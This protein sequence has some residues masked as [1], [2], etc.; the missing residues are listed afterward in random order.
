MTTTSQLD[1]ALLRLEERE[2]S[3]RVRT[4]LYTLIP[5]VLAGALIV[6]Y[7]SWTHAQNVRLANEIQARKDDA[8]DAEL[9]AANER[10]QFESARRQD[11]ERQVQG[12]IDGPV[13]AYAR[14][15]QF[16]GELVIADTLDAAKQLFEKRKG[17]LVA[18]IHNSE[19]RAAESEIEELI[20]SGTD[21]E[22]IEDRLRPLV[23]RLSLASRHAWEADKDH[24]PENALVEFERAL[25]QRAIET[26]R[27]LAHAEDFTETQKLRDEFWRLYWGELP[28]VESKELEGA[29]VQFGRAL[30]LWNEG[31]RPDT[32]DF[33]ML[34]RAVA[35]AAGQSIDQDLG[36]GESANKAVNRSTHSRGN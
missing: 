1:D 3:S 34:A 26:T 25:Y 6:S 16:G 11:L 7:V 8:R 4:I 27:N 5:T 21:L 24:L 30:E 17:S 28:L 15:G 13:Q 31:K 29:M 20:R 18:Y 14:P 35:T 23:L 19:I 2:R 22:S 12:L 9:L 36:K 33:E 10:A 32:V